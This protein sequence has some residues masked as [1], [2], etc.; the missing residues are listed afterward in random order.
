[1]SQFAVVN[2]NGQATIVSSTERGAKNYATRNDYKVV[3][4]VSPYSMTCYNLQQ[5]QGKNWVVIPD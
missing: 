4:K 3:C 1:M 2:H 5:K